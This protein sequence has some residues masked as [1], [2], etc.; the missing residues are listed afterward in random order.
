MDVILLALLED[1]SER[2]LIVII[3]DVMQDTV[4][5]ALPIGLL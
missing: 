4:L 5:A 3:S 2:V 1:L